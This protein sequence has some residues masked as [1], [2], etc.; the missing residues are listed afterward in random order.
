MSILRL[1]SFPSLSLLLR[2]DLSFFLSFRFRSLSLSP[3]WR[4]RW[5]L[6]ECSGERDRRRVRFD[7]RL[8]SSEAESDS[9]S[10]S[11][12]RERERER[13]LRRRPWPWSWRDLDVDCGSGQERH[14]VF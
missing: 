1:S 9:E 14:G 4:E 11:S 12:E 8:E 13:L 6:F 10:E 7:G 5:L 3:R 2:S